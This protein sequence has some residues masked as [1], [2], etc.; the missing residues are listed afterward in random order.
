MSCEKFAGYL[1]HASF[2]RC[3]PISAPVDEMQGIMPVPL[4]PGFCGH[5]QLQSGEAP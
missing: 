3:L 2:L 5:V 4:E 1:S